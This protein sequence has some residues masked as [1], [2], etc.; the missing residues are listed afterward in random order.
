MR[1]HVRIQPGRSNSRATQCRQQ[2]YGFDHS[3]PRTR[4]PQNENY[5]QDNPGLV[6]CFRSSF[7]VFG[8]SDF[9]AG[10]CRRELGERPWSMASK[11]ISRLA[12]QLPACRGQPAADNC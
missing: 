1:I 12:S 11:I 7:V 9:L 2:R 10:I 6:S 8:Q 3:C 4:R 5:M